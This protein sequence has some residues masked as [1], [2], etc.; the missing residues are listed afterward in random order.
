MA[1]SDI[2]PE[3]E[4]NLRERVKRELA[5]KDFAVLEGVAR[6]KD[7]TTFPVEMNLRIVQLD[8]KYYVVV[9]RDIT[10][11]RQAEMRLREFERVF[12]NVDEM[13]VV[14]D[15]DYRYVMANRAALNWRGIAK[16]QVL[17]FSIAEVVTPELYDVIKG[18]IDECFSGK[19][20]TQELRYAYPGTGAKMYRSL[21]RR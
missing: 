9:S 16:E 13:I 20:V 4:K 10:E 1:V 11:R 7:G 17:P 12:E 5:G 6:R 15:R 8:R 19:V 2:C 3:P 21:I 14:V 18:K